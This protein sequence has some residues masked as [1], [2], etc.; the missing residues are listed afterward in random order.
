MLQ[1]N[2]Y[3]FETYDAYDGE[4]IKKTPFFQKDMLIT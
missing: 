2:T 3:I 1:L 4:I